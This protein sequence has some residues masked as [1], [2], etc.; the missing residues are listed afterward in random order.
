MYKHIFASL[1]IGHGV[2]TKKE[3]LLKCS[4]KSFL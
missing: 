4:M 2:E 1:S 3:H